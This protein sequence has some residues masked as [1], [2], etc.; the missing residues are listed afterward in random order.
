MLKTVESK[1]YVLLAKSSYEELQ[2]TIRES[3]NRPCDQNR[4]SLLEKE[5][6]L[7]Q[8]FSTDSETLAQLSLKGREGTAASAAATRPVD[9]FIDSS[10]TLQNKSGS[11]TSTSS[12]NTAH[13]L[14]IE[15][16]IQKL[17]E[18]GQTGGKI[19]RSRA[20]LKLV[21]RSNNVLVDKASRKFY[22]PKDN[23]ISESGILDFLI[24]LQLPNKKLK[25]ADLKVAKEL[26]IGAHI[27]A[28]TYAKKV[29]IESAAEN[30][31]G[32]PSSTTADQQPSKID[33]GSSSSSSGEATVGSSSNII[34]SLGFGSLQDNTTTT[35]SPSSSTTKSRVEDTNND[36]ASPPKVQ[37]AT[38]M[39][40][41][42]QEVYSSD[43]DDSGQ[44]DSQAASATASILP[45]WSSLFGGYR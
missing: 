15:A 28:N 19:E 25:P 16:I 8:P 9:K 45:P 10:T 35:T 42:R 7:A 6:I 33:F 32:N 20:I 26:G 37:R 22:I 34:S 23:V 12:K 13:R 1:K 3:P 41:R 4:L 14:R 17:L 40:P 44:N 24:N 27:V 31:L 39:E 43:D 2:R 30:F 18:A 36:R 38:I 5:A 11:S 21:D 29:C